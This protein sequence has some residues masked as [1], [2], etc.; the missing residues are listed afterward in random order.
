MLVEPSLAYQ[1]MSEFYDISAQEFFAKTCRISV[2]RESRPIA[3]RTFPN[4]T[5]EVM[6]A[7]FF[8]RF[9]YFPEKIG[10]LKATLQIV[11]QT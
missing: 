6:P 2:T 11:K 5:H 9:G 7:L 8:A 10:E 4:D 1:F 3:S